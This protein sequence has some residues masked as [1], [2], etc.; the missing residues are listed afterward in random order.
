MVYDHAQ[1]SWK[2]STNEPLNQIGPSAMRL[3]AT[4]FIPRFLRFR[5]LKILRCLQLFQLFQLSNIPFNHGSYLTILSPNL[6]RPPLVARYAPSDPPEP[7]STSVLYSCCRSYRCR[8]FLTSGEESLAYPKA[9]QLRN[10]AT[11]HLLTTTTN[12]TDVITDGIQGRNV[13]WQCA[14]VYDSA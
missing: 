6:Y 13:I 14:M 11:P 5:A 3:D 9:P 2:S 12:A 4:I 10:I 7:L 1:H 8:R